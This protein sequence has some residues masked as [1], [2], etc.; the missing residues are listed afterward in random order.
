M[1]KNI[2]LITLFVLFALPAYAE[3]PAA[4]FIVR[5]FSR[6]C[7]ESSAAPDKVKVYAEKQKLGQIEDPAALEV[8]VGEGGKGAAWAVPAQAGKFVLSV[9]GKTQACAVWAQAADPAEVETQYQAIIK[10]VQRPG[11]SVSVVSDQ[12]EPS[13]QGTMRTLIYRV[14][15]ESAKRGFLFTMLT[16]QKSGGPFQ[17]SLQQAIFTEK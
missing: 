14:A 9:R 10:G 17:V 8:F 7:A 1:R 4:S 16:T 13:P 15:P 2:A 11:I 12:T 3:D 6:V 5:L